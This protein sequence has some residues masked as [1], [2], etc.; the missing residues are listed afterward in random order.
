[1]IEGPAAAVW[2]DWLLLLGFVFGSGGVF[3][4]GQWLYQQR[5]TVEQV[6]V[7]FRAMV[8]STLSKLVDNVGGVQ[9]RVDKLSNA[10]S[11][12]RA[13]Q[14]DYASDIAIWEGECDS[15]GVVHCTFVSKAWTE[16]TGLDKHESDGRRWLSC[17]ADED[18]ERVD[19]AATRA[20]DDL[21]YLNVRYT[22]VNQ[23]S[24]RRT[25]CTHT[26]THVLNNGLGL[27]GWRGK[28]IPDKP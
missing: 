11:I 26:G 7:E 5:Q 19:R 27:A 13:W 24:G 16:L 14:Q 23:K 18:R 12:A 10:I 9:E 22:V 17:V 4:I 25:T 8:R 6:T 21:S 15:M 20:S 3:K 28:L 1:M 2:K